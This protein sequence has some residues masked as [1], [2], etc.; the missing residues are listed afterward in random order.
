MIYKKASRKPKGTSNGY[1]SQYLS[2]SLTQSQISAELAPKLATPKKDKLS[3]FEQE[4][5]N[6][7][8]IQQKSYLD[9]KNRVAELRRTFE[10]MKRSKKP[11]RD[12]PKLIS[13]KMEQLDNLKRKLLKKNMNEEDTWKKKEALLQKNCHQKIRYLNK[14]CTAIMHDGSEEI[15]RIDHN[16]DKYIRQME[17]DILK[18]T[19]SRSSA[20]HKQYSQLFDRV[21][22]LISLCQ[23]DIQKQQHFDLN[24]K[25]E[26]I[27]KE[28]KQLIDGEAATRVDNHLKLLN[29]IETTNT[30]IRMLQDVRQSEFI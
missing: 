12:L 20:F 18:E 30:Q 26:A 11:K 15:D 4:L 8:Q 13:D 3:L 22:K 25:K 23:E 29:L 5:W 6:F 27:L 19:N 10:M 16:V 17:T 1:S 9:A 7:E 21:N 24:L 2:K 14:Q 28:V